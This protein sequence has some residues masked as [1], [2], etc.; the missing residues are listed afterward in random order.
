[1]RVSVVV[2]ELLR[3][4]PALE[5]GLLSCSI[6]E[7]GRF[8]SRVA[9]D[10]RLGSAVLATRD[11][12]SEAMVLSHDRGHCELC[13]R[14]SSRPLYSLPLVARATLVG[15]FRG[16]RLT[17]AG[18]GRG[19]SRRLGPRDAAAGELRGLGSLST[20]SVHSH[21]LVELYIIPQSI[22]S[23]L[24]ARLLDSLQFIDLIHQRR[25]NGPGQ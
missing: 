18:V 23:T 17:R 5:S 13:D 9:A 14:C 7:V 20:Y 22:Y 11:G 10:V 15:L 8:R 19:P 12:G 24:C 2:V 3:V 25:T 21:V 4:V 6:A 16:S 1:M